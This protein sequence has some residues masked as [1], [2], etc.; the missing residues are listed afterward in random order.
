MIQGYRNRRFKRPAGKY[1][2][3]DQRL[4]GELAKALSNPGHVRADAYQLEFLN[5]RLMDRQAAHWRR[6]NFGAGAGSREGITAPAQYPINWN[7]LVVGVM[8]FGTQPSPAFRIPR[9]FWMTPSG[10]PAGG[11]NPARLGQDQF[12]LRGM[13]VGRGFGRP[14]TAK[15]TAGIASRN[16]LDAGVR[17]V[18]NELPRSYAAI[19]A[20]LYQE[21][22]SQ[23]LA[24]SGRARVPRPTIPRIRRLY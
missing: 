1:R 2:P 7:G 3:G 14:S 5:T 17:R 11:A 19:Y 22:R 13:R 23:L 6:L 8:G 18:A 20:D 15:V 16:F 21:A 24:I 12:Y 10:E 4:S 9:G